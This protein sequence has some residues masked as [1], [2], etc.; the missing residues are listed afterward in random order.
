MSWFNSGGNMSIIFNTRHALLLSELRVL[1]PRTQRSKGAECPRNRVDLW[2]QIRPIHEP[3]QATRQTQTRSV[4]VRGQSTVMFSPCTRARPRPIHSRSRGLA[5]ATDKNY[6][7]TGHDT[8]LSASTFPP[9]AGNVHE[10]RHA[11]KC[12]LREIG[13]STQFANSTLNSS[14]PIT[15][16]VPI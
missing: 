1:C 16:Y 7:L 2:P 8:G 15:S 11:D 5:F 10:L 3:E 14:H 4:Q 6:P 12:P 9:Q 13:M